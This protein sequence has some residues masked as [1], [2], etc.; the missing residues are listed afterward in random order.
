DRVEYT[1]QNNELSPLII[2]EPIGW[3]NDEKELSRNDDYHGIFIKHSNNLK[4]IG[5]GAEYI[6]LTYA[7]YGINARVI[8]RKRERH[9]HNNLWEVSYLGFLDMSTYSVEKGV[10][11][12]KF[13]SSGMEQ[14]L[15]TRN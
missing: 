8:L 13:N 5:D 10:V 3:E 9:P 4:F 14:L 2:D 1:L 11:S 15:K 6:T 12:V 7:I